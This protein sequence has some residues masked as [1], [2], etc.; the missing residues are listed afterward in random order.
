MDGATVG[1][2]CWVLISF[3]EEFFS[4]NLL[5]GKC[6]PIVMAT[7]HRKRFVWTNF[8]LSVS[9]GG[10]TGWKCSKLSH[11]SNF[12]VTVFELS[13]RNNCESLEV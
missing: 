10:K 5:S 12:K 11:F 4:G 6:L 9:G 1:K 7:V 8:L 3:E 13:F 2:S